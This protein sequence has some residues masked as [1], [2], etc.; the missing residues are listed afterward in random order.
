MFYPGFG[1]KHFSLP[2][3]DP[4]IFNHGSNITREKKK[5][6]Y[7]YSCSSWLQGHVLIVQKIIHPG[8]RSRGK[9]ATDHRFVFATLIFH[10]CEQYTGIPY[11]TGITCLLSYGELSNS[12][13]H[14]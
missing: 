5:N 9:K 7:L 3:P 11:N 6:N 14:L 10:F 8:Y 4:K 2:D 1:S 13:S 12:F